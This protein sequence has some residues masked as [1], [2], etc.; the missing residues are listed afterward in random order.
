M[1]SSQL[2]LPRRGR[3]PADDENDEDDDDDFE[4]PSASPPARLLPLAMDAA[5]AYCSWTIA[6]RAAMISLESFFSHSEAG[7]SL[8]RDSIAVPDCG[9]R[10]QHRRRQQMSSHAMF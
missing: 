2:L 3:V 10:G 8:E 5:A 7:C 6:V 1:E 4:C 9:S